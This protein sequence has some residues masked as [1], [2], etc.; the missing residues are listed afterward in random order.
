MSDHPCE[1][2]VDEDGDRQHDEVR[3][4]PVGIKPQGTEKKPGEPE[5]I[6][7]ERLEQVIPSQGEREKNEDE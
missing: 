4:I 6:H 7:P 1:R 2:D 3:G 5:F